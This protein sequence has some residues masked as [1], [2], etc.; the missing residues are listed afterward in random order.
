[1]NAIA[2]GLA[3]ALFRRHGLR[4]MRVLLAILML[5]VATPASAV[6]PVALYAPFV[7]YLSAIVPH[8]EPGKR[9]SEHVEDRGSDKEW[10]VVRI[11]LPQPSRDLRPLLP[12][13]GGRQVTDT[14]PR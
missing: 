1:M 14:A 7:R 8:Y 5:T 4:P 3:F 6:D 10:P 11:P 12:L 13:P 2:L 9:E